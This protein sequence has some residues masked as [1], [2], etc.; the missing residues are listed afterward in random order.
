MVNFMNTGMFRDSVELFS[1]DEQLKKWLPKITNY[2]IHGCYA[3]TEL[4]HGSDVQRLETTAT[5]DPETDEFV[6][7]SPTPS[8]TKW[9]PGELGR[10]AN[11][12]LV[13]AKMII[14]GNDYG[15]SPFLV[16]IRSL[17]THKWMPGV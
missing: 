3:Q 13:F 16:Q 6:L 2:D 14:D 1:N 12:A 4:G 17:E 9:W 5:F 7:N 15:I 8:S 10:F 11:Y